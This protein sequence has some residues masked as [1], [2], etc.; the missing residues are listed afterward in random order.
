MKPIVAPGKHKGKEAVCQEAAAIFLVPSYLT[1]CLPSFKLDISA[2]FTFLV[3]VTWIILLS[4][5]CLG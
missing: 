5:S 2:S 1:S 3:L 4:F